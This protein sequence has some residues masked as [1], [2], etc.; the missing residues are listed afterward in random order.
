[1]R[2]DLRPSDRRLEA[3]GLSGNPST[4]RLG[5]RGGRAAESG[6][7]PAM[8]SEQRAAAT[9]APDPRAVAR[10]SRA[11][12]AAVTVHGRSS[13]I[14]SFFNIALYMTIIGVRA[15]T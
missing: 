7:E 14:S 3:D 9:E 12:P 4:P 15:K 1:V 5:G 2:D 8:L 10:T 13:S 11:P 6:V